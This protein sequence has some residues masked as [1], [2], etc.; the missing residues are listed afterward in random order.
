MP[1]PNTPQITVEIGF[2]SAPLATPVWTDVSDYVLA[3]QTRRGR[4]TE[5]SRIEAGE[6][7]LTLDNDDGRFTPLN[8]QSPYF[9][10]VLPGRRIRVSA[11][12][13]GITYRLFTGFITGWPPEWAGGLTGQIQIRAV[14]GF[15][16]LA[17]ATVTASRSE[18]T[19]T[20]RVIALLAAVGWPNSDRDIG[21][22]QSS[23][24][25]MT[26]AQTPALQAL[27]DA[28]ETENGLFF[29]SGAGLATL[30]QR[31]RRLLAIRSTAVQAT[32]GDATG[33]LPYQR[34]ELLY[35]DLY[36]YNRV[37]LARI[38]GTTQIASD[39]T[40]QTAYGLSTYTRNNLGI[41]TD[42]EVAD[43]AAWILT[44]SAQPDIRARAISFSGYDDDSLWPYA[45]S[46][47][48]SDL[49]VVRKR[50]PG[51]SDTI[52]RQVYAESVAHT[53]T[54]E[55]WTTMLQLSPASSVPWLVLDDTERGVLDTNALAY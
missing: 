53:I 26:Y 11:T 47:E 50:P 41:T 27:L 33:E 32:F 14:D 52:E 1:V 20:N 31:H 7:T 42:N 48:I 23:I 2:G 55:S 36:I 3:I 15:R 22:S 18:E 35:D 43:A 49:L 12:W 29:I 19:V 21:N 40:S 28:A 30:H 45:L 5:L 6:L 51:S 9:P 44:S 38:G 46:A 17:K 37:E 54:P 39:T 34:L 25:A 10:N 4:Q 8:S 13:G 24:Q 16:R